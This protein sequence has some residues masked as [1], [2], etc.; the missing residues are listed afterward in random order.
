MFPSCTKEDDREFTIEALK[1]LSG[2][3]VRVINA[4]TLEE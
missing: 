4:K 2:E 3:E 1:K